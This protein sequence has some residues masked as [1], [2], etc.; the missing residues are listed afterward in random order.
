MN[1]ESDSSYY[2]EES[3]E[4]ESSEEEWLECV[5][6]KD[7]E[8]SNKYPHNIRRK[9]TKRNIAKTL[10]KDGYLV[11]ALNKKDYKHHRIVALQFIP[12]DNPDKNQVDHINR[13]KTDNHI[14]NLRWVDRFENNHNRGG[15]FKPFVYT[16]EIDEKAMKIEK[17]GNREL[18]NYYYDF[19]LDQFYHYEDKRYRLLRVVHRNKGYDYVYMYDKNGARFEFN[20]NVFKADLELE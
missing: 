15:I 20:L 3:E 12:N 5:V 8:I 10:K 4:N 9:G 14:S 1:Y 11:C 6:D 16:D 13:V 17:Y 18:E 19:N 2:S 7:Y